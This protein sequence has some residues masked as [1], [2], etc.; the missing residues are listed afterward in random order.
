MSHILFLEVSKDVFYLNEEINQEKENNKS[1]K[2]W[3]QPGK[4]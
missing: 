2:S 1:W 3:L 4:Q